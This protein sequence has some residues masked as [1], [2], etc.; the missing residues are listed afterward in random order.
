[1]V[2]ALFEPVLQCVSRYTASRLVVAVFVML[3]VYEQVH[4]LV[5]VSCINVVF[6]LTLGLG[7]L[8]SLA[9]SLVRGISVK[10]SL[11]C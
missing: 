5:C 6:E 2:N 10:S 3:A 1:M 4:A 8:L 7:V 9:L 11:M